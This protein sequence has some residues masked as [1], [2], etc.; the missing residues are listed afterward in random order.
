MILGLSL[1]LCVRFN[2]VDDESISNIKKYELEFDMYNKDVSLEKWST[3][4]GPFPIPECS[5]I[6]FESLN[7]KTSPSYVPINQY[8]L[9][10]YA[11]FLI[12]TKQHVEY[13]V[14][15]FLVFHFLQ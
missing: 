9:N 10:E 6:N 3:S 7:C 2:S 11:L 1:I 14:F 5:L 13:H 8:V 15:S 12:W 4:I